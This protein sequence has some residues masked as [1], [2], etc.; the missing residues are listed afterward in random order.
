MAMAPTIW[1]VR[2]IQIALLVSIALYLAAGEVS[3]RKMNRAFVLRNPSNTL[4]HALSFISISL[5][6][7]TVVVRRTLVTPSEIALQESIDDKLAEAR[8]RTGYVFLYVLCE[9][10]GFF[11]LILRLDGFTLANVWGFYLGGFLL[12]LLYSP[13]TPVPRFSRR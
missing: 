10:L 7:V 8:W 6:G 12:L 4:F 2:Q 3:S 5:V 9:V 11:G 13:R 1:R